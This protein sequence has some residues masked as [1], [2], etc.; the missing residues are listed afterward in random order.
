[1]KTKLLIIILIIGCTTLSCEDWLKETSGTE[2][3]IDSQ[4]KN[5]S[6]FRDALI[7]VYLGMGEPN[8]Y[9]QNLTW[10]FIEFIAQQY[11]QIS[12]MYNIYLLSYRYN[13]NR[14]VPYIDNIWKGEYNLIANVNNMLFELEKRQESVSPLFY[15]L[16]KGELLGLRA[17]FHFDLLRMYGYGNWNNRTDLNSRYTIPYVT[18]YSKELTPQLTYVETFKLIEKDLEEALEL[19][20]ED[21]IYGAHEDDDTYYDDVD[22]NYWFFTYNR[23]YRMNYY[24]VRALQART[25]LWEGSPGSKAKALSAA[26]EVIES[27]IWEWI[28]PRSLTN[29]NPDYRDMTFSDEH[30]FSIYV[31]D[32][33]KIIGVWFDASNPNATYERCFLTESR[34]KTVFEASDP[35]KELDIRYNN[36]LERQGAGLRN[37][38]PRKL[39]QSENNSSYGQRI[40][41]I[42]ISEMFY[43]AAEC[44]TTGANKNYSKAIEYLNEVRENRN[45]T[46]P[47]DDH[48]T[49]SEIMDEIKKEYMKEFICEGQLFYFYK[50]LGFKGILDYTGEMTDE[51]YMLPYPVAEVTYGNRVQ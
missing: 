16:M 35:E 19:L 2:M 38:A 51:Q 10:H 17:F 40:P 5:E 28:N 29:S 45:I 42:R 48:L 31:S 14:V 47:L 23:Q 3:S 50:R 15:K 24:A 33:K 44:L 11:A 27:D 46:Q 20:K 32:L 21:Y 37:Y 34:A 13:E 22:G 1:M 6:G 43:I 36:L 39:F 18:K 25:W 26:E 30:I 49:E 4:F 7:G 8:L 12:G 41:L 9:A